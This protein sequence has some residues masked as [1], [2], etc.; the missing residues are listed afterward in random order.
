[1]VAARFHIGRISEIH[2][3]ML[4]LALETSDLGGS[5]SLDDGKLLIYTALKPS[6]RS[7]RWLAP[8]VDDALCEACREPR[9]IDLIAVTTGPGSFTGLRV[10][11][12]MAKTLAY[13]VGC[14][15][16]GVN[17]L[18][19]IA[20]RVVILQSLVWALV[21]AQR[22]QVF[23]AKF[24]PDGGMMVPE[25]AT[26]IY[27]LPDLL[28]QL[29]PGDVVTG[30][31]L[32]KLLDTLPA[33]LKVAEAELWSPRAIEV[34]NVGL[35]AFARGQRED[36]FALVPQYFRP[37]AAEEAWARKNAPPAA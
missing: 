37:T 18:Q 23:A 11:V 8:A 16:V 17:T 32:S 13:A 27:S 4:V 22:Q 9:E 19:A 26:A 30:P 5:I 20:Q 36:P 1:M 10:G 3:C 14:P 2:W 12:T 28:A 24:R 6:Q 31:G 7:A 33:G 15:I 21:D 25:T 34:A 29:E 35:A